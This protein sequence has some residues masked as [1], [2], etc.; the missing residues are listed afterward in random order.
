MKIYAAK[1][2]TVDKESLKRSIFYLF[3]Y[4]SEQ[5]NLE[6]GQLKIKKMEL[7]RGGHGSRV[8]YVLDI[9]YKINDIL[10][11]LSIED[12]PMNQEIP[13]DFWIDYKR[14]PWYKI[15]FSQEFMETIEDEVTIDI[16]KLNDAF[17]EF[18]QVINTNSNQIMYS[19]SQS[20]TYLSEC[21][22]R[23]YSNG[24]WAFRANVFG[25]NNPNFKCKKCSW[26]TWE[27]TK[28]DTGKSIK[29][30]LNFN[31]IFI[32]YN[33]I[34]GQFVDDNGNTINN[35]SEH[36]ESRID[37]NESKIQEELN[38]FRY[39]KMYYRKVSEIDEYI[40][41][42]LIDGAVFVVMSDIEKMPNLL[43]DATHDGASLCKSDYGEI[44]DVLTVDKEELDKVVKR[45]NTWVKGRTSRSKNKTAQDE[46]RVIYEDLD[47]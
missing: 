19:F 39:Q 1:K 9:Y 22:D 25:I 15:S 42:Q 3:N 5:L 28:I 8:Y 6:P 14:Y 12:V 37:E 7:Y 43:Y 11:K 23:E 17:E 31:N 32:H 33:V 38:K 34:S 29:V 24:I 26:Y 4:V 46:E 36:L 13:E 35:I 47:E 45:I 41:S 21:L 18:K 2:L 20:E 16:N 40:N 27:I 30:Q 10:D 44:E